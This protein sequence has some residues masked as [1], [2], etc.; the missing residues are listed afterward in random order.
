MVPFVMA[1]QELIK[2]LRRREASSLE[3]RTPPNKTTIPAN[4][5]F[6]AESTAS[7]DSWSSSDSRAEHFTHQFAY[8]FINAS[9]LSVKTCIGNIPWLQQS[10]NELIS[11]FNSSVFVQLIF[12]TQEN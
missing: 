4:P 5:K 7:S 6:S 11:R 1:N 10:C 3:T 2:I 8:Q 9:L 12:S